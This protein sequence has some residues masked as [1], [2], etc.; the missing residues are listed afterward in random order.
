[1]HGAG[2]LSRRAMSVIGLAA[3]SIQAESVA[4]FL[5]GLRAVAGELV[6]LR[7]S[8]MPISNSVRDLLH[9]IEEKAEEEQ[10]V[11]RLRSYAQAASKRLTRTSLR[12]TQKAASHAAA[13]ICDG[14]IVMTCSYS[15]AVVRSLEL[16]KKKGKTFSVVAARSEARDGRAYGEAMAEKLASIGIP[17]EVIPDDTLESRVAKASKALTGADTVLPDGSI[18]NG[19]PT[20]RLAQA[21][22]RHGVPFYVVCETAKF[23]PLGQAST[24]EEGFELIPSR[25]LA[26]IVTEDGLK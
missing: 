22:K 25:L 11:S 20:L 15:T 17:T 13:L 8:M 23:A 3:E 4:D 19:A 6:S 7:P 2:W 10:D 26:R 12:A 5:Q 16:A 14:D 21:A 1:M 24:L 9:L 18:I